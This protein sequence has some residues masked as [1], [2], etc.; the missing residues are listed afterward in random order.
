VLTDKLKK[1]KINRQEIQK[2]NIVIPEHNRIIVSI[3]KI[4]KKCQLLE[5]EKCENDLYGSCFRM[6][7]EKKFK[8]L[9]L[10]RTGK[11]FFIFNLLNQ[12]V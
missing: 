9:N 2:L 8:F 7:D 10:L 3:D 5:H 11:V 6:V 12:S 4:C 1:K